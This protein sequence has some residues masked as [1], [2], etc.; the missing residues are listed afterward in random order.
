[1]RFKIGNTAKAIAMLLLLG[2]CHPTHKM[3][4]A[5]SQKAAAPAPVALNDTTP[6]VTGIGGIFF[7]ADS[8]KESKDWYSKNLGIDVNPWGSA[9]FDYTSPSRPEDTI[10]LQWKPFKKGDAYF[11]PS[12]KDFMINY[13]VQN[14]EGLVSKLKANG[15]TLLDTMET[16]D[17]G[18]FIHIMDAEGRKIELWEPAQ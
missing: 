18:K 9:S 7:Y 4:R 11:A 5:D 16:Y 10:S 12:Q 1:M 3:A 8:P 17:Y 15:V 6:K 2:S 13:T 14:L